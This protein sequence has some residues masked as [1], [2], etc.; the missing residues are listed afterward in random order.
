M[1]KFITSRV[2]SEIRYFLMSLMQ[3]R[4]KYRDKKKSLII[5]IKINRKITLINSFIID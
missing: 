1:V 3:R 5:M 2:F 4:P